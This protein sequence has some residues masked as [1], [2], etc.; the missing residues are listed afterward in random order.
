MKT[1][2]AIFLILIVLVGCSK[3]DKSTPEN[4]SKDY[5]TFKS[6]DGDFTAKGVI[7]VNLQ[8]VD[9]FYSITGIELNG[10]IERSLSFFIPENIFSQGSYCLVNS[11]EECFMIYLVNTHWYGSKA[12]SEIPIGQIHIEELDD[13]HV[14]GTF[15]CIVTDED[16]KNNLIEITEGK[17][18]V[19]RN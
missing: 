11:I 14:K 9:G 8:Y 1:I 15:K 5:M 16:N 2:P 18:Y 19:T 6:N 17:F 4:I 3:D 10:N 12:E 7:P 13:K